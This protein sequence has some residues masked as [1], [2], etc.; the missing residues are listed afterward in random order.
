GERPGGGGRARNAGGG[1][2]AAGQGGG[3][4]LHRHFPADPGIAGPVDLAHA[5]GTERAENLVGAEMA[6]G[7]DGHDGR[8]ERWYYLLESAVS[9]VGSGWSFAPDWFAIR[10]GI[11]A[12]QT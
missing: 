3:R 4:A 9:V 6:A 10:R 5:A 12:R 7:R 1:L 2:G 11:L 8:G